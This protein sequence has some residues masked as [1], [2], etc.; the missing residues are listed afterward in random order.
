MA[1]LVAWRA[2]EGCEYFKM[3]QPRQNQLDFYVYVCKN[4]VCINGICVNRSRNTFV[5]ITK[6]L[7]TEFCITMIDHSLFGPVACTSCK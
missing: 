5:R 1:L 3:V 4:Q 2:A 6:A 7:W